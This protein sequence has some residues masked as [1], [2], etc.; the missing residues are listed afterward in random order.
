M[1]VSLANWLHFFARAAVGLT[2]S[3]DKIVGLAIDRAI[4]S[5]TNVAIGF[6]ELFLW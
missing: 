2:D 3:L 6:S 4:L 1:I 5:K